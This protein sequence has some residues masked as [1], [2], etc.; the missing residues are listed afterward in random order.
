MLSKCKFFLPTLT[1]LAKCNDRHVFCISVKDK[2][3]KKD[4][5][6]YTTFVTKKNCNQHTVQIEIYIYTILIF[7]FLQNVMPDT[8]FVKLSKY[9][10]IN[11]DPM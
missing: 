3:S 11:S 8:F 10:K 5:N 1:V 4:M 2:N 9:H 7:F 6:N